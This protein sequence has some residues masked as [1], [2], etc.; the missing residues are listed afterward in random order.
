MPIC[1]CRDR[2]VA[3]LAWSFTAGIIGRVA[4][5][6]IAIIAITTSSS[7]SVKPRRASVVFVFIAVP[8]L[9]RVR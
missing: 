3:T 1:S 9:R 7:I 4:A 8:P 2:H 6:M 5:I